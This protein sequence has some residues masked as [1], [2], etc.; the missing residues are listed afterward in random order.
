MAHEK[1]LRDYQLIL[2]VQLYNCVL[3]SEFGDLYMWGWNE[4]GQLGLTVT[5]DC[6]DRQSS[7]DQVQCQTFP[8]PINFPDDLEI[9]MVSCGTRHTAAVAGMQ[10]WSN[11]DISKFHYK[12]TL[13]PI[14]AT[15]PQQSEFYV[16]T[17]RQSI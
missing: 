17:V 11:C 8:V 13:E 7:S 14:T 3:P 12:Y 9:L 4:K 16:S 6:N 5:Q 1:I 2:T 10:N 15:S